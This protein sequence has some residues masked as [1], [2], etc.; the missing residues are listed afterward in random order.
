M[1]LSKY[2]AVA[3]AMPRDRVNEVAWSDYP[4]LWDRHDEFSPPH[5][6]LVLLFQDFLSKIPGKHKDI[7]RHGF[8]KRLGRTD[9][10]PFS[11]H[12]FALLVN[13]AVDDE[14]NQIWA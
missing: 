4:R 3:I 11:R 6:V 10:K 14:I 2:I 13:V 9:R 12:I 8:E 5:A 1:S 7:I